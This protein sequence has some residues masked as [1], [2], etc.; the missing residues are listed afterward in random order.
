MTLRRPIP[1]D[2]PLTVKEG[3][4][5]TL[6]LWDEA[7]LIAEA[8]PT[9]LTLEVPPPP[10]LQEATAASKRYVG[11]HDHVFPTCFVCGPERHPGDGLRIFAGP[12]GSQ[13]IVA[14]PW[15]PDASLADAEGRVES[16]FL[17]AALDCPGAFGA[18]QI[19]GMR[20]MLL[21]RLEGWVE[22]H[23]FAGEPSVVLGWHMATD[24]R[25]HLTGTAIYSESGQLC[26]SARATWIEPRA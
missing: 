11:F 13:P 15:T 1:L 22:P 12:T 5:A 8:E 2:Q 18:M 7:A 14:A 3:R 17:W 26:G 10:S 6:S 20:P 16:V 23:L 25:K 9:S 21:G 19:V 4:S 24:G